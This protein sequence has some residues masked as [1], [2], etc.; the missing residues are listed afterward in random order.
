[1][2]KFAVVSFL[3]VILLVGCNQVPSELMA[4]QYTEDQLM[5]QICSQ[6]KQCA[7]ADSEIWFIDQGF[8]FS[9]EK[10]SWTKSYKNGFE[11]KMILNYKGVMVGL[12]FD[13]DIY[14]SVKGEE[15]DREW[16]SVG[17][18]ATEIFTAKNDLVALTVN[19]EL[20]R[21]KGSPGELIWTY[22]PIMIP[23]TISCGQNCSTI[24]YNTI[25]VPTIAG[26]QIAF[27]NTGLPHIKS[28]KELGE[29]LEIILNE[30][31]SDGSV[32]LYSQLEH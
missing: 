11:V 12:Q 25:I 23:Y 9:Y 20:W 18:S 30:S 2:M 22:V 26:R 6:P 14:I 27:E 10:K 4:K 15:G 24:A 29:D 3:A 7:D 31:P 8:L 21:Y 28:V 32:I 16:L 13:G 19:N 1:M 5:E 17:N